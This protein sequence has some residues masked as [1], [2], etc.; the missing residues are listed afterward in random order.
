MIRDKKVFSQHALN[1][2]NL[3]PFHI[4]VIYIYQSAY[5]PIAFCHVDLTWIVFIVHLNKEAIN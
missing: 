4:S 3:R 5:K 2:N 1:A